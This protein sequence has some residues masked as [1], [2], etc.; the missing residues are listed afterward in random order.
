MKDEM[1]G[2][3]IVEFVGLK[4]KM[5]SL[6]DE[7][8]LEVNKAKGMNLK[9]RHKEYADVLFNKKIVRHKMKRI[10]SNLHK[11]GTYGIIKIS[12]S[13]FDDKRYILDGINTLA[14]GHKDIV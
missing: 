13:C 7:N 5:Y 4:S 14:Y 11:T 2:I 3:K 12:L 8:D 9:L 6:I 10:Q 1:N